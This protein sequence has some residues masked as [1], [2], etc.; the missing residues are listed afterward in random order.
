MTAIAALESGK[1]SPSEH[2]S[3]GG[4]HEQGN[5]VFHCTSSHGSVDLSSAIQRSCNIYFWKVA[6]RIGLDR[7]AE[8]AR[9]LGFGEA[10]GLDLNDEVPGAN[11]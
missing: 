6:E 4:A 8:T 10:T 11:P 2:F 3:C 5:H 7:I 1:L 9:A